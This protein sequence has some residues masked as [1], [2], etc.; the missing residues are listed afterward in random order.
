MPVPPMDETFP[1]A[2]L[3]LFPVAYD[4]LV[5][6]SAENHGEVFRG[7]CIGYSPFVFKENIDDEYGVNIYAA[8]FLKHG[9]DLLQSSFFFQFICD[10]CD[11][12]LDNL[13]PI[14]PIRRAS[15]KSPSLSSIIAIYK[16]TLPELWDLTE[17]SEK[18]RLTTCD[19]QTKRAAVISNTHQGVEAVQEIIHS[20]SSS[21]P[22]GV[23]IKEKG[24]QVHIKV[25]PL[26]P[27]ERDTD[28]RVALFMSGR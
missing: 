1:D 26:R 9:I 13:P 27:V 11:R 7:D 25:Q 12:I 19:R 2:S 16:L 3:R 6:L 5:P 15:R 17:W 24:I 14:L 10:S 4:M 20:L 18:S 28:D 22:A 23:Y 21:V 8:C